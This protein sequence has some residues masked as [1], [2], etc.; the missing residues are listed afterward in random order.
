M[1]QWGRR[2]LSWPADAPGALCWATLAGAT[3]PSK[4]ISCRQI[5]FG[6]L[7]SASPVGVHRGLAARVFRYALRVLMG[8]RNCCSLS[9]A[10]VTL[11]SA[12]GVIP[13]CAPGL[14]E[15]WK[16]CCVRPALATTSF[17]LRQAESSQLP[18]LATFL[19]CHPGLDFS[20]SVHCSW[21]PASLVWEWTLARC[22]HHPFLDGRPALHLALHQPCLCGSDDWSLFD[23]LRPCPLFCP[24]R[25]TCFQRLH[26]LLHMCPLL[27]AFAKH[28]G[29]CYAA[30]DH[31]VPLVSS[32]MPEHCEQISC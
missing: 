6:R 1:R 21:L 22:G 31:M 12:F 26:S 30:L 24:W 4:C 15:R 20:S 7:F 2:L 3:S 10:G 19:Q 8:T 25:R 27:R 5:C 32:V 9:S 13:G 29:P 16:E 28:K 23:A 14:V 18:Y 11:P 17:R